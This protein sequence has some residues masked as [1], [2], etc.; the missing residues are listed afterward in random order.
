MLRSQLKEVVGTD[1]SELESRVVDQLRGITERHSTEATRVSAAVLELSSEAFQ[2][3]LT[4]MVL[5][6]VSLSPSHFNRKLDDQLTGLEVVKRALR[7]LLPRPIRRRLMLRDALTLAREMLDRHCGRSVTDL[8]ESQ[9][10][11]R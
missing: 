7:G 8:A 4:P 2:V 6:E 9:T 10:A 3:D 5:V 11:E 1:L